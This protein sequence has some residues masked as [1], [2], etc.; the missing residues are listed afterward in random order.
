MTRNPEKGWAPNHFMIHSF[1][2]FWKDAPST[3]G[4]ET[5]GTDTDRKGAC[6]TFDIRTDY[7][8]GTYK[9]T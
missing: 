5:T 3:W 4:L 9:R 1:T 8:A 7:S 2:K 6:A